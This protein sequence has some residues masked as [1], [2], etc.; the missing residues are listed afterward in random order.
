MQFFRIFAV[1]DAEVFLFAEFLNSGF[2]GGANVDCAGFV[3]V[4]VEIGFRFLKIRF[5]FYVNRNFLFIGVRGIKFGVF[6][7]RIG[8]PLFGY[9]I[10][11]FIIGRQ[12]D[13]VVWKIL[14]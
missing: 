8:R 9:L 10:P 3:V 5:I 2:K 6:P 4:V 12:K 1:F 11:H 14:V 7:F 13:L